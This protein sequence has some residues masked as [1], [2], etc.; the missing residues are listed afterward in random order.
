M[1]FYNF[2]ILMFLDTKQAKSIPRRRSILTLSSSKRK[3]R[4]VFFHI[5]KLFLKLIYNK[6]LGKLWLA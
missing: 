6:T 1:F 2:H 4:K 3:P 5:I